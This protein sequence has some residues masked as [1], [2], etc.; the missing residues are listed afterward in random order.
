MSDSLS[1]A[2]DAVCKQLPRT[3]TRWVNRFL[4]QIEEALAAGHTRKAVWKRL[5]QQRA[6][7]GY[8]EFCVYLGR[9]RRSRAKGSDE[10]RIERQERAAP[11]SPPPTHDPFA[12]LRRAEAERTVFNWRG[13]RDLDELVYGKKR[14]D[15]ES[16]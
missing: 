6:D 12:N 9:L 15:K 4:P 5:H 8:K 1:D 2:L 11:T 16:G 14:T 10:C 13:T 7:L 3:K